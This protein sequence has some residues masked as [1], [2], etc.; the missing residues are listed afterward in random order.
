MRS[1]RFEINDEII[2]SKILVVL[3]KNMK[4]FTTSWELYRKE[5]RNWEIESLDYW[6]KKVET[7]RIVRKQRLK[8]SQ[9]NV[10]TVIRSNT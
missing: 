5:R 7:E 1:L 8:F 9:E 6:P 3:P 10:L 2:I 4:H